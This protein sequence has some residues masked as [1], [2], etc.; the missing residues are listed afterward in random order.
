MG[1]GISGWVLT[2]TWL[3]FWQVVG[4]SLLTA[5][6]DILECSESI[7]AD[8]FQAARLHLGCLGVVLTVTFQCVPQ[9]HLHEVTFPSTLTEVWC[10]LCSQSLLGDKQSSWQKWLEGDWEVVGN[11]MSVLRLYPLCRL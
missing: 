5:S 3:C 2:D 7:N 1:S 8:I 11:T 10:W 9:F 4:L 6:G